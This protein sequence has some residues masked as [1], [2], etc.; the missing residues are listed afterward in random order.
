ME[1]PK[2]I[3]FDPATMWM[4]AIATAVFLSM[5]I[6]QGAAFF[7]PRLM[8]REVAPAAFVMTGTVGDSSRILTFD[9]KSVAACERERDI[10][11]K[12]VWQTPDTKVDVV[13]I[14]LGADR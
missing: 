7:W 13:C 12:K 1:D 9:A 11:L 5:T 10:I 6:T 2:T 14:A 3:K 4:L 8:L